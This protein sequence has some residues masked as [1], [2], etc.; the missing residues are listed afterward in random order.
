MS[1]GKQG[2]PGIHASWEARWGQCKYSVSNL[3]KFV[4]VAFLALRTRSMLHDQVPKLRSF[5]F[6]Q[7]YSNLTIQS[8]KSYS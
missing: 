3:K 5:V 4:P 7:S 2:E 8:Y 6:E 1:G